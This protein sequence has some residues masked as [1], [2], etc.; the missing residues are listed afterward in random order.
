LHGISTLEEAN[1]FLREEY[2]AEFNQRFHFPDDLRAS[3]C[4]PNQPI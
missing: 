3:N 4:C 1:V 2:V